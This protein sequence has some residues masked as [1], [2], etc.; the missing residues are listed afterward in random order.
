VL[1]GCGGGSTEDQDDVAASDS[2]YHFAD[3]SDE[4]D[5]NCYGNPREEPLE[6]FSVD[7][8]F[9]N[10]REEQAQL[11]DCLGRESAEVSYQ[12]TI[13]QEGETT[14]AEYTITMTRVD[15]VVSHKGAM[16]RGGKRIEFELN[17]TTARVGGTDTVPQEV[18]SNGE[19]SLL[20][21]FAIDALTRL[22]LGHTGY[23]VGVA[24]MVT[25]VNFELVGDNSAWSF[26]DEGDNVR[27]KLE[28]L[29]LARIKSDTKAETIDLLLTSGNVPL[30]ARMRFV[31]TDFETDFS[32]TIR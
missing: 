26:I 21:V 16:V 8:G 22:A 6:F 24:G 20:D 15:G 1:A 32:M 19:D 30:E 12:I 5:M 13:N 10:D 17:D 14:H 27:A 29:T 25:G 2:E 28:N 9:L 3:A 11:L 23:M 4:W 31:G 18:A 7:A